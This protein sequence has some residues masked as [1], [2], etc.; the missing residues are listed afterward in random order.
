MI[1]CCFANT[2]D[3]V[4]GSKA[5]VFDVTT[6]VDCQNVETWIAK[7][8]RCDCDDHLLAEFLQAFP[9][10]CARVDFTGH[11]WDS[12]EHSGLLADCFGRMW[13]NLCLCGFRDVFLDAVCPTGPNPKLDIKLVSETWIRWLW[14]LGFDSLWMKNARTGPQKKKSVHWTLQLKVNS[15]GWSR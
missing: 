3:T 12:A 6:Q 14:L 9:Q 2:G 10:I 7:R 11:L 15:F 8:S 4:F 1:F 13:Q 5:S